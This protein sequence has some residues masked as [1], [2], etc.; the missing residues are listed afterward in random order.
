MEDEKLQQL[1]DELI[2]SPQ[3]TKNNSALLQFDI[4]IGFCL[5]K[6]QKKTLTLKKMIDEN[7]INNDFYKLL[8]KLELS[9]LT[10]L[11]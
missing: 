11:K 2:N 3:N 10:N 6:L 7:Q 4:L 1:V 9:V 5:I 8:E